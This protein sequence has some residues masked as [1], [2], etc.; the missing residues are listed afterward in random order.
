MENKRAFT[1][2][3]TSVGATKRAIWPSL[4]C[5]NKERAFLSRYN[6][7]IIATPLDLGTF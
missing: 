4:S 5:S 6:V 3:C 7:S 1:A 2:L